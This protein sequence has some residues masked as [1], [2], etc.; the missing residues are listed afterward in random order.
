MS[1]VTCW[2]VKTLQWRPGNVRCRSEILS[3]GPRPWEEAEKVWLPNSMHCWSLI[4][5]GYGKSGWARAIP[6]NEKR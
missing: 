3:M 1:R 2:T 4:P 6:Y 5:M